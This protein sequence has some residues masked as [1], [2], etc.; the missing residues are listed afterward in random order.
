[1][2][3]HPFNSKHLSWLLLL[4][5]AINFFYNI[6]EVPLFDLDEGAF[7]EATR[8]MFVRN[9]FSTTYLNGEPRHDKPILIYWLQAASV[10]IFGLN[11]FALRLPSALSST[12]WVFGIYFFTSKL[13]NRE[14]G[15]FAAIILASTV[16][17]SIIAKAATA[18][19]LLNFLLAATMMMLFLYY[20]KQEKRYLYLTFLFMGLGFLT[21]GP[22]ALMIP[23]I[24]SFIFYFLKKR[25]HDWVRAVFNP[26]GI[27]IFTATA[28][29]WYAVQY[30][31]EGNHFIEGF[32]FK[33]NIGRLSDPMESHGGN[34]LFYI[35]VILVGLI[36]YTAILFLILK[37]FRVILQNDLQL[38][39]L[40]WFSFVFIFFS[41]SGTKLPHYII[42]GYT[43]LFILLGI[44][45]NEIRSRALSLTP[46]LFFFLFLALLPEILTFAQPHIKDRYFQDAL[47]NIGVFFTLDYRLFFLACIAATIYF[48]IEKRITIT[49]KLVVCGI[50]TV[51]SISHFLT[52]TIANIIQSPVKEAAIITKEKDYKIVM[53]KLNT[54]SFNVYSERLVEKRTPRPGDIVITKAYHLKGIN[55]FE[56]IFEKNGIAL[57]KIF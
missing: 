33:H 47:E 11:E 48:M 32:F 42:Y 45:I 54:P 35:P 13:V 52:P 31:Q 51:V 18:D 37:K 50:L 2:I 41:F 23:F 57:V 53:W 56:M 16:E 1:M 24:V 5:V 21:K 22:V 19:A 30:F 3:N 40:I 14:T 20:K 12:L 43:G 4:A 25:M 36:P 10:S 28:L 15:L 34:I 26:I 7:S 27:V 17:V 44:Y 46:A 39:C 9:D 6:H 8:E 38:Y 29:P 55:K 49:S